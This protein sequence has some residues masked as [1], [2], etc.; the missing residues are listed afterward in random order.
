MAAGLR[1][2]EPPALRA[3]PRSGAGEPWGIYAAVP[4]CRAKCS[5]CNFASG[6]FAPALWPRY[7]AALEREVG[8]TLTAVAPGTRPAADTI[9]WGGGTPTLLPPA[10]LTA[11]AKMLRGAFSVAAGAEFTCEAMPGTVD[12]AVCAAMAEAG[13][14]RVSLGVQSWLPE[15]ARRVGRNHTP[16]SIRSDLARLRACGLGNLSLDLIAGLPG[17]T[18]ASWRESVRRTVDSGVP[19]VSVYLFELDA[20][21]RLGAEI[22]AGGTRYGAAEMPDPDETADWYEAAAE[23]LGQAGLA[24]YEIS[25]FA[26]PGFASRHNERYWLRRPYL[27]FGLEAHSFLRQ[28]EARRWGNTAD[29]REY[30]TA[31]EA[32][33]PP[34]AEQTALTPAQA[35][36]EALFLGLRRNAGVEWAALREEFGGEPVESKQVVAAELAAAGCLEER[37]GQVALTARGRL[38]ANEVFE[39]FLA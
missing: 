7:L 28:P 25:N 33:R 9:Y 8:L 37:N 36:E 30:L 4:F 20:E 6:V 29:M 15:E 23:T 12:A 35:L 24:Q 32:G 31:V 26:R 16:A 18:A 3:A 1:P 5:F 39:R 2:A 27:G 22:L 19:H 17:Q 13:I 34:V 14:N 38:L 10:D 11:L 21:S